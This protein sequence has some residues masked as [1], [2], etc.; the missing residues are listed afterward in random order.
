MTA[1]TLMLVGG[2]GAFL[3]TLYWV[4]S[5]DLREKY[6]VIWMLVASMLLVNGLFPSLIMSFASASHLQYPTAV[7]FVALAMMYL[8]SFTVSVTQEMALLELRL[9][10]LELRE[11]IGGREETAL[12]TA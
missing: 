4:R 5:R 6:A 9:R 1:E 11:E 2:V 12:P 7:L 10:R 8:F 3:L